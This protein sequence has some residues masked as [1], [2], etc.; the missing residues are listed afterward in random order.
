MADTDVRT[1]RLNP[2]SAIFRT[3]G[4]WYV[5]EFCRFITAMDGM[6]V[7]F[8]AVHLAEGELSGAE[9]RISD[10]LGQMR[11]YFYESEARER[12]SFVPP[13]AP[14]PEFFSVLAADQS[15]YMAF[16]YDNVRTLAPDDQLTVDSV[17]MGSPGWFSFQGL[18]RSPI[19]LSL[20]LS[21]AAVARSLESSEGD[22]GG[23]HSK[24][25]PSRALQALHVKSRDVTVPALV[26]SGAS[27]RATNLP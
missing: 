3:D 11:A 1:F 10:Y 26:V 22:I 23:T 8:L 4:T 20:P 27:L 19:A 25:S 21:Y 18:P 6:Y 17:R 12:G 24:Y 2:N 16:V 14:P 7:A 5:D 9:A 15:R 13:S